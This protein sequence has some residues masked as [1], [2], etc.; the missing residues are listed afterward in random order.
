[1]KKTWSKK[2]RDTVPLMPLYYLKNA[3]H[4]MK[5]SVQ[6]GSIQYPK[7]HTI[8]TSK[9]GPKSLHLFISHQSIFLIFQMS[10]VSATIPPSSRASVL[11]S[12]ELTHSK[13]VYCTVPV[14]RS[15][16]FLKLTI[17]SQMSLVY[18][19]FRPHPTLKLFA[20][21]RTFLFLKLPSTHLHWLFCLKSVHP[22]WALLSLKN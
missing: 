20:S 10:P 11:S 8:F 15:L 1:M 13:N 14:L 7:L 16:L 19:T 2:S 6:K 4:Y 21:L 3:F 18:K 5:T 22:C 12:S 9:T 17:W